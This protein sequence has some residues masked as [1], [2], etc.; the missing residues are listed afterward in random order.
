MQPGTP[1]PHPPG[2][3]PTWTGAPPPGPGPVIAAVA[4]GCWAVATTLLSQWLGWL[5]DQ[6]LLVSGI[7]QPAWLWPLIGLLAALLVGLPAIPLATLPR[8]R[9][10]RAAGR[11]WLVGAILLG[12]LGLL[13]AV[14]LPSHE[15]YLAGLAA[16]AA[17]AAALIRRLTGRP[18]GAPGRGATRSALGLGVAG[19]LALLVPWMWLGALGG[20]VE[21]LAAAVA[22]ASVGW[23]VSTVLGDGFWTA[24]QRPAGRIRLLL[25]GGLVAGVALLLIAAGVGQ[26]GTQLAEMLVLP[27]VGFV[28][29]TLWL[30]GAG[31]AV[32][33][34]Q[35]VGAS[36]SSAGSPAVAWL[37]GLAAFGPLAY[38]DPE[39]IT[40]LLAMNIDVPVW[41][42]VA[43]VAS[44][45]VAL[46][47]GLGF[48]V[49]FRRPGR[50][51]S[52]WVTAATVAAV[53]VATGGIYVGLGQPGLYGERLFVVLKEQADLSGIAPGTGQAGRD[54]RAREVY[55]RLTETAERTQANLRRDLDRWGLDH[56]PYYLVNAVEVAGGPEVR[57]WLSR[58][59][60]VA[61]VLVSQRL[62]PIPRQPD[63][64]RG[65]I[66]APTSPEWNLTMIGAPRVWSELGVDGTGIVVGTSDS[67]VDGTHPELA[68]GFRGGDDSWRDPWHGRTRPTD[69]NGH[70]THTL[71]TA[72]GQRVG[73]APGA[74][75]AGCVNLDRNLGNPA[76]YLDCLQFML[77]PY[78][79]GGDPFVD[80]RTERAPHILTNS[81]GCPPIEGC[82]PT[83]LAPATAALATAGI[84]F[85][86]AAGNTGPFC[87]SVDDPPA[88]YADVLTVG[89]VDRQG[90]VA[91]FSSR[92]PTPT[93]ARKPDLVAP[94]AGVLSAMPGGGYTRQDGTSMATPHVAGVVA[95]LWSANPALIGDLERTRR[96]LE[97]T[98]TTVDDTERGSDDCGSPAYLR[99][100]GLVNAYAAVSAGMS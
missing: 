100:A 49:G 62:R 87:G 53:L 59:T 81:W 7:D 73:V 94:G 8:S 43:A 33:R 50:P 86:V 68:A 36:A 9:G 41:A 70:G 14:P 64:A 5:V 2:Y 58:R 92:G 35:A 56:T 52:R 98:A 72:V 46:L 40:L 55:R 11:V 80:G 69:R 38:A 17:L 77:A 23:L 32:D 89:A 67:G 25:L 31:R 66:T 76:Y 71:A 65:E 13:R 90:R 45:V 78:P 47:L 21:T 10:V 6:V 28:L 3:H 19:G 39:E 93:G 15:L 82:D 88:P 83:V 79:A 42:G 44:L 30:L 54:A 26:A 27:P 95:L 97:E 48:G 12:A 60:D 37:V 22:A 20:L 57:A 34:G 29:A 63:A 61:R 74:R 24:Y 18:A 75:W 16:V 51:P 4:L 96:I 99:G 84:F 91:A 85:V 1:P